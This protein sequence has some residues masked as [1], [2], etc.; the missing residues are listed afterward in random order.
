PFGG[1]QEHQCNTSYGQVLVTGTHLRDTI[2]A[3]E[4]SHQWWG[5]AVSPRL[6]ADVWLN[7][8]FASYCEALWDEHIN[9]TAHYHQFMQGFYRTTWS[10]TVYNPS[11]LFG[12]TVY[13]KGAWVQHM[14]RHVVGDAAFFQAQRNWYANHQYAA[15]DTAGYQAEVEAAAASGSLTWFFDEW[16]NGLGMPNYSW[17]WSAA[18]TGSGYKLYVRVDQA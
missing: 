14:L 8:G 11:N 6:W 7:E 5:D 1:A 10:G 15:G 4:L 18:N 9:G 13:Y 12:R 3:H 17:A 2:I 16:L